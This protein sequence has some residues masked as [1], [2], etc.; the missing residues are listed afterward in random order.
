MNPEEYSNL[1]RIETRHWFYVGKR[2]IVRHW[3]QQFHPLKPEH[4]LADCGAGTGEFAV[5]MSPHCRV[6]AVDDYPESLQLLRERLGEL[7]VR[8]GSCAKLPLEADSVDVLTALD[9]VEHI[10]NDRAALAEFLRVLK[11]GGLCIITVPA[12]MSLWSD[13]DVTLRH[14]RRY[15]RQSLLTLVPGGFEVLHVNYVNV[16]VLPLVWGVRKWRAFKQ[17]LGLKTTRRSEDSIPF[18]LL[19]ELLRRLFVGL[20]CQRKLSFPAGVGLIAVLRKKS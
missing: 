18:A 13:W 20:A 2:E 6:I 7:R 17:K 15:T 5:E 1:A 19:N 10:E 11:P 8:K 12:L 16:V 14:F 3:I 4:C 9:V